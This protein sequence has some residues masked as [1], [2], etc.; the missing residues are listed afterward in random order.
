MRYDNTYENKKSKKDNKMDRNKIIRKKINFI[1]YV[2]IIFIIVLD[3][4]NHI[5]SKCILP[6]IELKFSNITLRIKGIGN[7]NIFGNDTYFKNIYYPNEIYINGDKQDIV[8]K[9]YNFNETDNFVELKWNIVINNSNY[10]FEKCSD[11]T[12]IDLSDFDSSRVTN[13]GYMFYG[14][15]SLS[16]LN[17]TNFDTS[18]V[19][20][21]YWMFY[22]CSSLSSLNLSNFNTSKVTNMGSMFYGCSSL[23]YLNLSS[24]STI[25]VTAMYSMFRKCKAL[26][27]LNVS[28]FNTSNVDNMSHMFRECIL[29]TSLNLSNFDTSKV[30]HLQ[31]MFTDCLK[32]E[33]INMKNF[34]DNKANYT[35][36]FSKVPNNIVVCLYE[37]DSFNYNISSE[38]KKKNC[39]NMDC[40]DDWNQKQKM[41]IN[42]PI[43]GCECELNNCL[44]CPNLNLNQ[45]LC[46][47]C[48]SGYYKIENDSSSIEKYGKCYKEPN[49]YYLD[50]NNYMYKECFFSCETCEKKGDN[51]TH[52]CLKCKKN[53]PIE[54]DFNNYTNCFENCTYYYYYDKQNNYHC[55]INSSCPNEY[56]VL[57]PETKECTN[58][59]NKK[60]KSSEIIYDKYFS[61]IFGKTDYNEINY[62]YDQEIQIMTSQ[63]EKVIKI[64]DIINIIKNLKISEKNVSEI[65]EKEEIKYY[66]I[67][68]KNVESIFT[69]ENYD[70]SILDKGEDE[71]IVAEKMSIT[72]TTTK[73][74]RNNTNNNVTTIDFGECET[75]IRAHYN[76]SNNETIYMKKIDV[77]QEGMKIPKVKYE[78]YCKFSGTKLE[79][80]NLSICENSKIS[81]SIPV[82][83]TESID[84]LNSSSGYYKDKCYT[85]TSDSGTDIILKDRQKE[86]VEGN[87]T[88]CQENCDF[89]DYNHNLQK[90]NCSCKIDDSSTSFIDMNIN[91]TQ[92]YENFGDIRYKKEIS[93]LGVTSCNVLSSK[94]NVESNPGF[95]LLLFILA[96]FIII[97]IIFS[98]KGY[99]LLEDKIDKV[100]YKKF[101]NE[102]NNS[103]GKIK[104]QNKIKLKITKNLNSKRNENKKSIRTENSNKF[105][106]NS[107]RVKHIQTNNISSIIKNKTTEHNKTKR[108]KPENDYELNWS[109]YEDA[110]KYDK[111]TNCDYYSSLI[112][113]KQLLIFT[114]CSFNDYNSGI[115]K[116]FIFFLS[117]ALHY[118]INALFFNE[119]TLHK[120][121]E[122]EGKFNFENQISNILYSAII[123]TFILRL[124]LHILILTDKD[125]LE[126]RLQQT[127]KMA[128]NMKE[129]KLK[130]MK[131]KFT[132]FFIL[133]FIMLVIFWYYLTCFNAIYKN[134]QVYLI[135]NTFI[136]FGFS[137]CYP[138]IVNILP[139]IIRAFSL[140]SSENNQVY[141]YK[142]S[143]IL[144]LI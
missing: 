127:K 125:I 111:R 67:I 74:Q 50:I 63:L 88:V 104:K 143:K 68:M 140:H 85:A 19:V 117:F 40:S 82:I 114:F 56:P 128:I 144:Q 131:I 108:N 60:Y 53:F 2:I 133:N 25:L 95:Y 48:K 46:T 9:S 18:S 71:T 112:K 86:Y 33:Y 110:L 93:N 129:K 11:I 52:N 81:L 57:I 14:C 96:I 12:E 8:K 22:G 5:L 38:L 42:K 118:T 107:K 89:S 16:S 43:N 64:D 32:L 27:S 77:K 73:N 103:K 7:K 134:T 135:E 78:I 137:L 132:I 1:N 55:T 124:M 84:K 98:T 4:F 10:M 79:K 75:L 113:S 13:M 70:T 29:L 59:Y 101:K 39:Y 54:I 61:S 83:L 102:T 139:T 138:F 30:K 49:G 21:M 35:S 31:F 106:T 141:C 91:K 115:I 69:S 76:I 123:S 23:V 17:L 72:F 90:A 136:S 62:T 58:D 122:E 26:T 94:E 37:N 116:K 15:S 28:N 47:K 87:K 119:S 45:N 126:V 130:C 80:L 34:N 109:S 100:I 92:L 120:I 105:F 97:F 51:M 6:S 41:I 44:S 99:N 20:T 142:L 121:Y 66:D 65:K 3:S 36:I 24:F